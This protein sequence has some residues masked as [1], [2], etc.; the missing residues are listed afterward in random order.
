VDV[1]GAVSLRTCPAQPCAG[2]AAAAEAIKPTIGL[3][4]T[5]PHLPAGSD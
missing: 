2:S 4:R 3:D 1:A 5:T